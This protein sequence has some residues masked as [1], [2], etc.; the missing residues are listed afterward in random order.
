MNKPRE[1][2]C[3]KNNPAQLFFSLNNFPVHVP[4]PTAALCFAAA[5]KGRN[6]IELS[7]YG[8]TETVDFLSESHAA[9]AD[10]YYRC[11]VF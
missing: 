5:Q 2:I 6:R 4:E 1:L 3:L 8:L 10:T 11:V 7:K 9:L